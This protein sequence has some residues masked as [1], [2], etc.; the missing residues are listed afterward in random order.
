MEKSFTTSLVVKNLNETVSFILLYVA[1]IDKLYNVE[2]DLATFT[3]A[4]QITT[5]F[6]HLMHR[7]KNTFK[8]FDA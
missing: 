1:I 8:L 2:K 4:I 7:N 5:F 6:D 3:N